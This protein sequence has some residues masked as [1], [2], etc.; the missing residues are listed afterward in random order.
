MAVGWDD[1]FQIALKF[2]FDCLG[3]V[4]VL[5][6]I[7]FPYV[8]LFGFPK[9]LLSSFVPALQNAPRSPDCCKIQM[10]ETGIEAFCCVSAL[11]AAGPDRFLRLK[12]SS[13]FR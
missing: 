10:W 1:L 12:I 3:F 9:W 2:F 7:I 5:S 11:P 6:L 13:I 8:I 4:I